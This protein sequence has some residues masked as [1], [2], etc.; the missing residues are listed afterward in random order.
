MGYPRVVVK[1]TT[2]NSICYGAQLMIPGVL[3]FENDIQMGK[4]IVLITTKGEAVALAIAQM[5]TAQIMTCDHGCVAKIKR[6]VMDRDVYPKKWGLGPYA[7]KK[8]Q[9]KK[10]GKLDDYGN[11]NEHT[12]DL[13]KQIFENDKKRIK[14]VEVEDG[15]M[16]AAIP[17]PEDAKE[18]DSDDE[19]KPKK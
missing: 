3:R 4:E 7:L 10:E 15:E 8:A 16:P 9:F 19:D 12:P 5:T 18:D 1:D 6:V 11:I 2:I 17:E 13:W 14:I